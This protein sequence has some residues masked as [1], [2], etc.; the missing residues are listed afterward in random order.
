LR[1]EASELKRQLEASSSSYQHQA[2]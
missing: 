2:K 1:S